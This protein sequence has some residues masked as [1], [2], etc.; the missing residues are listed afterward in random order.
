MPPVNNTTPPVLAVFDF[1]GT[2]TWRDTLVPFLLFS[3]GPLGFLRVMF[4]SL[5]WLLAYA[6]KLMGNQ[7]SKAQLLKFA[8][9][10]VPCAELDR[11]AITYVE[12]SL[13]NQWQP[14]TLAA[15]HRHQQAGHCCLIVSASPDIFIN[16]AAR[17]LGMDAVICTEMRRVDGLYTGDMATPNCHGEEK[18]RRLRAWLAINMPR[19]AQ[20]E[21]HI[22]G[23]SQGDIPM[24]RLAHFAW[25]RG[26]PWKD[27]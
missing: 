15:L 17:K 12:H 20:P 7:R 22:Y 4:M 3:L 10:H 6:L 5:P 21:I 14:W 11:K 9:A 23:D 27:Q 1:D 18:V 26:K 8:F 19:T 24:L 16:T 13:A 25:Y 2:L